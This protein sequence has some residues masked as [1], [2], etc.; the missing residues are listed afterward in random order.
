M[1]ISLEGCTL[2]NRGR[3]LRILITNAVGCLEGSKLQIVYCLPGR[4]PSTPSNP[5][6][7]SPV[8]QSIG[9]QPN[10]TVKPSAAKLNRKHSVTQGWHMLY[11]SYSTF[12]FKCEVGSQSLRL[13]RNGQRNTDCT[14]MHGLVFSRILWPYKFGFTHACSAD[15][16]WF[17]TQA[18]G[19]AWRLHISRLVDW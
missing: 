17:W 7:A 9:F 4:C 18:S 2:S 14:E 11:R 13:L 1:G 15:F 19:F 5:E 12:W 10:Q 3:S 8:T 16:N 6:T